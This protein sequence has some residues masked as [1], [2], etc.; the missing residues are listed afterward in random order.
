MPF[1]GLVLAA[2]KQELDVLTGGR[3]ERIYQP[4]KDEVVLSI[5][6]P[7]SK[8]RLVLSAHAYKTRIHTT[9]H[10]KEN[11]LNA[12]LFCMVLRKHLE[13][14]RICGFSQPGLDR[15]LIIDIEARD[16]L[17]QMTSKHLICEIMGK[18]SNIIL[19]DKERNTIIDGI[20]RY[21]HNV[22]R[23]REVLPGRVYLPPPE[24]NKQNPLLLNEDS[25]RKYL[26]AGSL[27][28][29]VTNIL[30]KSFD[31]LSP[32]ICREIIYR[33]GLDADL[34]LD[35]CGEHELRLLWQSLAAITENARKGVY[36]PV[37][38]FDRSGLPVDYAAFDISH[39]EGLSKQTSAMCS[40]LDQYYTAVYSL[41]LVNGQ[42]QALNQIVNKEMKRLQKK[43][44]IYQQNLV[45]AEEAEI[46]KLYGE[47]LTANLYRVSSKDTDV[48]LENF[49]RPGETV[50][51]KLDSRL[52]PSEN[53]QSYFKKYLKSKN[54]KLSA[55]ELSKQAHSDLAYLES[56][57]TAIA[58]AVTTAEMA[59]IKLELVEEGLLKETSRRI[60]HKK[61]KKDKKDRNKPRPMS[62]CSTDGIQILVGKNNKQNDYLTMK[63]ASEKDIWLHTKDIPGSHVIIRTEGKEVSENTLLEAASLAAYFSKARNLA[64]VPVDYTAR[65][66]VHKPNGA[67]PGYV[68][69]DKQ[70]TLLVAP[71][72]EL[73]ENLTAQKPL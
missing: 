35:H 47:L 16:E 23:Y 61:V 28:A 46:Y 22:S 36:Y 34:I 40:I 5:H 68:I 10:T 21:S 32:L 60:N 37:I 7:G 50:V 9:S 49:Y 15:V 8:Q 3:I 44:D 42:K 2:V 41:D 18:H 26:L 71:N 54:T 30:Q 19:V 56:V 62:F 48:E 11:P 67:K 14:G 25:F 69:Y 65:K 51:V 59:E 43:I 39:L 55:E 64:K 31:G 63:I 13:G 1:D 4:S 72:E 20:K 73:L 12:P 24:Q 17:G 27:E 6:R 33:S 70:K 57:E 52:S 45:D 53:A 58:Q 29:K 66:F 38:L